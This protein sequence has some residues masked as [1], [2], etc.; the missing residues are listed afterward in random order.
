MQITIEI[1]T[2][3]AAFDDYPEAEISLILSGL[4]LRLR[5]MLG[6][7]DVYN[8]RDSNG[9]VCGAVTIKEN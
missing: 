9:N 4:D 6:R 5:D 8:L 7:P 1:S 2:E 3:N